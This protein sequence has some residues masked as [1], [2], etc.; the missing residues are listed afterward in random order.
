[1]HYPA[2][3]F[4]VRANREVIL[5]AG[6]IGTPQILLL[7]GIGNKT[8]L[9]SLA[10]ASTANASSF[11]LPP[12]SQIID[13][14]D[15]G[16]HLQDHPLLPNYFL[17]N[18][19]LPNSDTFDNVL[20][21]RDVNGTLGGALVQEWM[22]TG[23]GLFVDAPANTLG[24]M[25]L[26]EGSSTGVIGAPSINV[27]FRGVPFTSEDVTGKRGQGIF[28][29]VGDR[30]VV[31]DAPGLG[32]V[33]GIQGVDPTAGPGSAHYE[34]LFAVRVSLSILFFETFQ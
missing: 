16:Q 8:T 4:I 12:P 30:E 29:L 1:M 3:K 17:V 11:T 13:L 18:T 21:N 34:I 10:T 9:T 25:R 32:A 28:K 14:P 20:P 24:F 6:S 7:S 31:P 26:A 27:P 5:S 33:A 19:S 23:G 22:E 2:P 15:V